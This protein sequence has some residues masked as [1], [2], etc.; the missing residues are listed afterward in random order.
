MPCICVFSYYF[1]YMLRNLT[2]FLNNN[3]KPLNWTTTT[4]QALIHFEKT[5]ARFAPVVHEG[6]YQGML[7]ADDA[8][9]LHEGQT[10]ADVPYLLQ[11]FW[12][13]NDMHWMEVLD[14]FAKNDTNIVPVL[15]AQQLYAGYYR[16]DDLL[17]FLTETPFLREP[18]GI[19]VIEKN[20]RDYS[21]SQVAQI[22]ESNNG[23]LLG[24]MI[25]AMEADKVQ[26]TLKLSQGPVND[27]L[28]A[29]RRY[30]YEVLSGHAEDS[31][32]ENLKERSAYLAR[33]LDL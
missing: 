23:R 31:Y 4:E 8:E 28:Q 30:D 12:A 1:A 32:L 9:V 27:I 16:L 5:D 25:T 33:F 20:Q 13:R 29:F 7:A 6:V 22:V 11:G 3:L 24:L 10:L 19:I 14:I 26:L 17:R 21:M 2:E 18:G 15:D